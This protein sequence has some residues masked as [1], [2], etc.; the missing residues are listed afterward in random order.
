MPEYVTVAKA[1]EIKPGERIVVEVK[2]RYIAI[3]NVSG[4]YYAI[5]DVCTHDD[6][7]LAEGELHGFEIEC[8]R[9]GARFDIRSGKVLSMP[10]VQDVARFEVRLEGDDLQ[11]L[12]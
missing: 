6:G 7:P 11:I 2:E 9:H 1:S 8:P 3:F 12:I 10:A 4:A 5:E